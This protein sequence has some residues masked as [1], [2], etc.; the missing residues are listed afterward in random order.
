MPYITTAELWQIIAIIIGTFLL[1]VASW[2]ITQALFPKYIRQTQDSYNRPWMNLL[3]GFAALLPALLM[4]KVLP[5]L[6]L[7][8]LVPLLVLSLAGSAGLAR[9]IGSG[10]I[11]PTDKDQPWRRTM[12]G[13]VTLGLTMLLPFVNIPPLIFVL[14]SGAGAS[15]RTLWKA[16][17]ERSK[18][19][20]GIGAEGD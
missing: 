12:R 9:R 17:Q 19:P 4:L 10:M 18:D 13:G 11:H 20:R 3:I 7:V 15:L 5:W 6:G 8:L 1:L 16:R 2:V 14:F